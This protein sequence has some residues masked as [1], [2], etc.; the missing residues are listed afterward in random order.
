MSTDD[1]TTRSIRLPSVI[2]DDNDDVGVS[3]GVEGVSVGAIS[4]IARSMLPPVV[5]C[6]ARLI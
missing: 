5:C 6:R 3:V 1:E 4:E 2:A